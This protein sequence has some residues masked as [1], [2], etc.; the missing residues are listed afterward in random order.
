MIFAYIDLS[1]S[2]QDF[3]FTIFD[4]DASQYEPK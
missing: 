2:R 3:S 4:K 1:N